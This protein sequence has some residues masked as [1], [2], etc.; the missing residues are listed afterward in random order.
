MQSK[1][2]ELHF[3][4]LLNDRHYY[5]LLGKEILSVVHVLNIYTIGPEVLLWSTRTEHTC[6]LGQHIKGEEVIP[7]TPARNFKGARKIFSTQ[8]WIR[9]WEGIKIFPLTQEVLN[10]P[11]LSRVIY[12]LLSLSDNI[13]RHTSWSSLVQIQ[14]GPW[15]SHQYR[16][17]YC[18][19]KTP[20]WEFLYR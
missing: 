1:K 12:K 16:D 20:Q 6:T 10:S 14:N 7:F 5:C 9:Y 19:D 4:P 18:E 8:Q 15:S 13:W 3:K 17:S 2:T 11:T